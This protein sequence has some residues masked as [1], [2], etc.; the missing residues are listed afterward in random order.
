VNEEARKRDRELARKR[1]RKRREDGSTPYDRAR[2]WATRELIELHRKEF[3]EL[4]L[5]Y[6]RSWLAHPSTRS[7]AAVEEKHG[8]SDEGT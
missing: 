8:G 3:D 6:L 2:N 7:G 4:R 5:G 1:M